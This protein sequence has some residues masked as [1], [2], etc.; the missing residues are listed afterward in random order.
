MERSSA[1]QESLEPASSPSS[2]SAA[3]LLDPH[4]EL[5]VQFAQ[6]NSIKTFC[7]SWLNLLCHLIPKVSGA[8]MLVGEPDGGSFNAAAMWP[9]GQKD[10]KRLV[11]SAQ[12]S[13]KERRGLIQP[14]DSSS[15]L[16]E[17]AFPLEVDGH[18][19]GVVVLEVHS[20]TDEALQNIRRQ[21][22]WASSWYEV[23]VRRQQAGEFHLVQ[24]RLQSA[25]ALV[26]TACDS[27]DFTH[28]ATAFV[29]ELATKFDCDRVSLG[30]LR[31][32]RVR[33]RALSHNAKLEKQTNLLHA[34][35]KAMDEALDQQEIVALPRTNASSAQ[36]IRAH[37]E[38]VRQ[39]GSGAVC[40]IPLQID[41][42]PIGV[43]TLERPEDRPFDRA[44]IEVCKAVAD[45]A[46]PIL[47][48]QRRN[49]RWLITKVGD[50]AWTTVK[51]LLGPKH[52]VMK[53]CT[54]LF[55]GMI[56]FFSVTQGEYRVSAKSVLE[57]LV[58]RAVVAPFNGYVETTHFRAGEIIQAGDVLCTLDDRELRLERLKWLNQLDE[59][60]KKH[61]QALATH[62]VAEAT[63]LMA[64]MEQARAQ[65][66][67]LEDQLARTKLVAPFDG[68][69]VTGDLSQKLGSPV[70]QGEVL[71]EVAPLDAYRLI[72]Q[73]D[74]RDVRDIAVDQRGQ[75][76]LS[77]LPKDPLSFSVK[78]ITPV[79][80]AEEGRNY[81]RVEARLD[82][83]LP[84]LR[85]GMEGVAKIEVDER[86]LIWIWTHSVVDWVR[87]TMWK[88]LP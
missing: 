78:N 17:V 22:Y 87:M 48:T 29:T 56:V 49:D 52:A 31:R 19:H 66:S 57:P 76:L 30:F 37:Q 83:T 18:L 4:S 44:T 23:M 70:E 12:R 38:L 28:A 67:L 53:L 62:E 68:V 77:S 9:T 60:E 47:E 51:H 61:D 79:S 16:Y 55:V 36:V 41:G 21:L 27:A 50:S 11:P 7:Q 71:F 2:A 32:G 74:E 85:P 34:V 88:W 33:V 75:L 54:L 58:L 84:R 13:L 10:V 43:L 20:Q 42:D 25:L 69:V 14:N 72:V 82:H 65:L 73:V 86:L 1:H 6:A 24:D 80:T 64:Q 5:W 15:D 63:I 40:S 45:L 39:F 46:G 8:I 26:G 81:F 59:L 35:G 3:N